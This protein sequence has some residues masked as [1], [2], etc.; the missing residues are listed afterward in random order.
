MAKV[1]GGFSFKNLTGFHLAMLGKQGWHLMAKPESLITRLFRV[2]YFLHSDF[3]GSQL[4]R[5]PNF[6][7]KRISSTK[8]IIQEDS[9]WSVWE[10]L[11][12]LFHCGMRTGCMTR[13]LVKPPNL[14]SSLE[15]MT[16]S[17]LLQ[18]HRKQWNYDLVYHMFNDATT[19]KIL[20]T[21]LIESFKE[22][23]CLVR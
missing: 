2:R 8:F 15:N 13:V 17:A 7:W 22:D 23:N 5:N 12:L 3:F 21:P 16:V 20:H 19:V 11:E 10:I 14:H 1:D 18:P 6:V 4:G 9:C